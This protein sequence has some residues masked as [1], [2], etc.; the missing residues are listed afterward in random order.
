MPTEKMNVEGGAFSPDSIEQSGDMLIAVGDTQ[1]SDVVTLRSWYSKNGF[2]W[3]IGNLHVTRKAPISQLKATLIRRGSGFLLLGLAAR[4][5]GLDHAFALQSSDGVNWTEFPPVP[6]RHY[7][8]APYVASAEEG[9][10]AMNDDIWLSRVGS[11]RWE[12]VPNPFTK[13]GPQNL[14]GDAFGTSAVAT[15]KNKPTAKTRISLLS[16]QGALPPR[17]VTIPELVVVSGMTTINSQVLLAGY[18]PAEDQGII[19]MPGESEEEDSHSEKIEAVCYLTKDEG[20]TWAELRPLPVPKG[21]LAEPGSAF[22]VGANYLVTGSIGDLARNVE[23][24]AVWVKSLSS[25]DWQLHRLPP[26]KTDQWSFG[27]IAQS[28]GKIIISTHLNYQSTIA[29]FYINS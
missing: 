8:M 28:D 20:R 4:D 12:A 5:S 15:C 13:C 16:I 6:S 29:G 26:L 23:H 19:D 9:V 3:R 10:L 21:S 17:L 25:D 2:D 11:M 22:T 27:T 24:P 1:S 18:K 7:L 14:F